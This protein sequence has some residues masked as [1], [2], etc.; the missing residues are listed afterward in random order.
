LTPLSVL[1]CG[2]V[3]MAFQS[4][5]PDVPRVQ[6]TPVTAQQPSTLAARNKTKSRLPQVQNAAN[7]DKKLFAVAPP[8]PA[9]VAVPAPVPAPLAAPCCGRVPAPTVAVAA[10]AAP[11]P[12][13]ALHAA[14]PVAAAAPAHARG[15]AATA[16]ARGFIARR[17]GKWDAACKR[18]M[19]TPPVPA[20]AAP[21][22]A[23]APLRAN[24]GTHT[25]DI[26]SPKLRKVTIISKSNGYITRGMPKAWKQKLLARPTRARRGPHPAPPPTFAYVTLRLPVHY[27]A[28]GVATA[29]LWGPATELNG[30]FANQR[31]WQRRHSAWHDACERRDGAGERAN[32]AE[33]ERKRADR[34]VRRSQVALQRAKKRHGSADSPGVIAAQAEAD[35]A[36]CRCTD[37]TAKLHAAERASHVAVQ[38]VHDA[39]ASLLAATSDDVVIVVPSTGKALTDGGIHARTPYAIHTEYGVAAERRSPSVVAVESTELALYARQ[40]PHQ[41][42]LELPH[43]NRGIGYARDTCLRVFSGKCQITEL[44]QRG[45]KC[46]QL[47]AVASAVLEGVDCRLPARPMFLVDDTTT[48]FK[49]PVLRTS[50]NGAFKWT[51]RR[52]GYVQLTVRAACTDIAGA[53]AR[54]QNYVALAGFQSGIRA[55]TN[56]KKNSVPDASGVAVSRN[57]PSLYKAVLVNCPLLQAKAPDVGYLTIDW[58]EDIA[59]GVSVLGR[60]LPTVSMQYPTR[61][62]SATATSAG[63]GGTS[64]Q[65]FIHT[66]QDFFN[67]GQN[68]VGWRNA[69]TLRQWEVNL[70]AQLRNWTWGRRWWGNAFGNKNP[71]RG[72]NARKTREPARDI[73]S[74]DDLCAGAWLFELDHLRDCQGVEPSVYARPV[75]V[76]LM[77]KHD[78]RWHTGLHPGRAARAKRRAIAIGRG[79]LKL[80]ADHGSAFFQGNAAEVARRCDHM[81]QV[82]DAVRD[83]VLG[84]VKGGSQ[85]FPHD[86]ETEW[87]A[88]LRD[89]L[90]E[91]ERELARRGVGTITTAMQSRR[92]CLVRD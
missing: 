85:G 89:A 39:E 59:F 37:A 88:K 66:V 41:V 48:F 17:R 51:S 25:G 69:H 87:V 52:T 28:E 58:P 49:D 36:E 65:R 71:T 77:N 67:R 33:L 61:W 3:A 55:G 57:T 2:V 83:D 38:A 15:C 43:I 84:W 80:C 6:G 27:E 53:V 81:L 20:E 9:P 5:Q 35:A 45:A 11:P 90:S 22:P 42:F 44:N 75:V 79:W 56:G 40:W 1:W 72:I 47:Q 7:L 34:C 76:A 78:L 19:S 30:L 14:P 29:R 86:P 50:A 23:A 26:I 21:A 10:C 70:L 32:A 18:V 46:S 92:D 91:V 31:L 16:L 62:F 60:G 74:L 82:I 13:A 64:R 4:P 63:G 8:A 12:P 24:N 68:R 54:E 73:G